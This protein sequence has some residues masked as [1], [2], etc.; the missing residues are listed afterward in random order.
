MSNARFFLQN[1]HN[2]LKTFFKGNYGVLT[3]PLHKGIR[4]HTVLKPCQTQNNNKQISFLYN[5]EISEYTHTRRTKRV[6]SSTM[7]VRG[8]NTFPLHNRL[9]IPYFWSRRP[10]YPFL[11]GFI[12]I[13]PF[14][15]RTNKIRWRFH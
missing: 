2:Q 13:F 14:F 1:Q 5:L 10:S 8:A 12:Y 3:F 11:W 9:P 4:R 6:P 15:F 7:D